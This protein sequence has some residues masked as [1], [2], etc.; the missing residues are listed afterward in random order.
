[1][2]PRQLHAFRSADCFQRSSSRC[3]Q[4]RALSNRMRAHPGASEAM[5]A[6]YQPR[7]LSTRFVSVSPRRN[8]PMFSARMDHVR[9]DVRGELADLWGVMMRFG[10]VHSGSPT[11]SGSVAVTSRPALARWPSSSASTRAASFTIL[12]R[13]ITS[14]CEPRFNL[15]SCSW[16]I[17]PRLPG[18]I[19]AEMASTSA[20]AHRSF[21]RAS[22]HTSSTP[23]PGGP[24][25]M[26]TARTRISKPVARRAMARPMLPKPT[27]PI[28]RPLMPLRLSS[29]PRQAWSSWRCSKARRPR[30][31]QS[32]IAKACS[33]MV[34]ACAPRML[35]TTTSDSAMPGTSHI[36]STPAL[37]DWTHRSCFPLANSSA[38]NWPKTASTSPINGAVGWSRGG[39]TNSTP[40]C[41][42]SAARRSGLRSK[43]VT[44]IFIGTHSSPAPQAITTLQPLGGACQAEGAPGRAPDEHA[45]REHAGHQGDDLSLL[46]PVGDDGLLAVERQ[47]EANDRIANS[48]DQEGQARPGPQA[49]AEQ[50][51]HRQEQDLGGD[52]ID[53]VRVG[54][55]ALE[56]SRQQVV[57]VGVA[58]RE[59]DWAARGIR[60]P[61]VAVA[62]TPQATDGLTDQHARRRDVQQGPG[63][64]TGSPGGD[65]TSDETADERAV[66]GDAAL[67]DR[68]DQER[69]FEVKT[70][71]IGHVEQARA[72]DAADDAPAADAVD[73]FP[74]DPLPLRQPPGEPQPRR[75]RQRREDAVPP[76]LERPHLGDQRIKPNV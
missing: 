69:V 16:P 44:S 29:A 36:H 37:E 68:R 5:R 39:T 59:T 45:E 41:C 12:P 60:P 38:F 27:M 14:R 71:V 2:A 11:G 49:V 7:C 52:L 40:C 34:A 21:N 43:E 76:E 22:G 48:H 70:Q 18:V 55:D 47:P 57:L 3:F 61:G 28:V 53:R 54:R 8:L 9:S 50:P 58:D 56:V 64:Q 46:Q 17:M 32:N 25:S 4:P 30:V 19:G 26:S 62:Q 51:Q 23:S 6:I 63:A 15:R 74:R 75:H 20:A 66:D 13:D 65:A 33:A 35:V 10:A 1:M 31:W 24:G 72:D 42:A 73:D 67:P